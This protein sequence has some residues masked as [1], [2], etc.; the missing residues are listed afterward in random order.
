MI[1][2]GMKKA[3][4]Q[5]LAGTM[6]VSTLLSGCGNENADTAASKS[7]EVSEETA[8]TGNGEKV[9]VRMIT[10]LGNPTRDAL[11]QEMV[12]DLENIELEILSPPTDQASQKIQTMLQTNDGSIDIVELNAMPFNFIQNGYLEPLDKYTNEWED[13]ETVTGFLK[14]QICSYD[15]KPYTIPYG[16]YERALFYRKDWLEEKGLEVPK[17]WEELYEVAVAL[18]DPAQNRYGYSFRGGASTSSYANMTVYSWIPSDIFDMTTASITKEGKHVMEYAEAVEALD[19][20]KKL[21]QDASSPDSIAWGYSEMVESF[22]SGVTGMV[23]QDPEVIQTCEQYMEE[24]TW[25]VAP[26]PV[27][28]SSKAIFPAGFS[29]FGIAAGSKVKDE[30]WQVIST[31]CG[32]EGNT[33]FCK[34]NGNIPIHTTAQEDPFFSEGYYK[35]YIDMAAEPDK[36]IG[37]IDGGESAYMTKE[38]M[39]YSASHTPNPD[40][41]IQQMLMDQMTPEECA[42]KLQKGTEWIKDSE[43]VQKRAAEFNG[44]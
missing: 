27:G 9:K 3:V 34:K 24:G 20:Y 33:Y 42:V 12:A 17:T 15:G 39:D 28:P 14:D 32:V 13:W 40:T 30:A 41:I 36:Y 5:I 1:R 23:I 43:W 19:F 35:C 29:G 2:K 37:F 21:Y 31:L 22:Y 25:D 16:I 4:A 11:M 7:P 38:E 44:Q 18:T 6:I 26:L 8:D 10:Y